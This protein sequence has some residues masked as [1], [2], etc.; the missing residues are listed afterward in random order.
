MGPEHNDFLILSFL[1]L[2][3]SKYCE[4]VIKKSLAVFS[5][6]LWKLQDF[7]VEQL[8][9]IL[10]KLVKVTDHFLQAPGCT[11]STGVQY[12]SQL[13]AQKHCV[14]ALGGVLHSLSSHAR[15]GTLIVA[16]RGVQLLIQA[17]AV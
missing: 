17:P 11:G 5:K 16:D 2:S 4:Q 10:E 6:L 7:D 14:E 9:P 8:P 13:S 1:V 12:D 3:N 15:P